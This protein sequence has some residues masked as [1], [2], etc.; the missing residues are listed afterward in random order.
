MNVICFLHGMINKHPAHNPRLRQNPKRVLPL[1]L[2][3][4]QEHYHVNPFY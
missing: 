3:T 1:N 2:N 4:I